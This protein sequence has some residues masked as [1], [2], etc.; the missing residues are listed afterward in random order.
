MKKRK[1]GL[2]SGPDLKGDAAAG[3]AS[4]EASGA[5]VALAIR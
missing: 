2:A 1:R 4:G 5:G 3:P